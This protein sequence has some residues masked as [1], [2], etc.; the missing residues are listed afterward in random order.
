MERIL[1]LESSQREDP[2]GIRQNRIA[3]FHG[4]S[5][6]QEVATTI[7]TAASRGIQRSKERLLWRPVEPSEQLQRQKSKNLSEM[8]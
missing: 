4:K 1:L 6:H 3:Q 7:R 2:N 8:L 5:S